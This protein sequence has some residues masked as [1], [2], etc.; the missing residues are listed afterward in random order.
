MIWFIVVVKTELGR[1]FRN[2]MV[3]IT[4]KPKCDVYISSLL[5]NYTNQLLENLK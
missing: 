1:V 2:K 3:A 4:S 5:M